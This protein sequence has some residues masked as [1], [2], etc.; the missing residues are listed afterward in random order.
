VVDGVV[1]GRFDLVESRPGR[2]VTKMDDVSHESNGSQIDLEGYRSCRNE[3]CTSLVLVEI[4]ERTRGLCTSCFRTHLGAQV[5]EVEVISRGDRM[6]VRSRK[7]RKSQTDKGDRTTERRS[8]SAQRRAYRRLRAV[9][10][11]LYDVF[12]AEERAR[13]GLNPWTIDSLVTEPSSLDAEQ[14]LDFARVYHHLLEHGV[15]VDGPEIQSQNEDP[16]PG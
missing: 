5:A 13:L 12:Y 4:A 14:T 1:D 16:Q 3:W 6:T 15:E 9:F 2:I 7:S 10:P 11:D 8:R